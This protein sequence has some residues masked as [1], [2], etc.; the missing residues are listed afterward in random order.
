MVTSYLNKLEENDEVRVDLELSAVLG[1]HVHDSLHYLCVTTGVDRETGRRG[2]V[3]VLL[4]GHCL[5]QVVL[6]QGTIL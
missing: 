3:R 5:V 4:E 2:E 1:N 6:R